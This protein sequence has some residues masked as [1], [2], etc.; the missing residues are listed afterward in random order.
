M[1]GYG[2]DG[3][4]RRGLVGSENPM[5]GKTGAKNPMFGK[6]HTPEALAKMRGR[7]M[8]E[9]AKAKLSESRKG[10]KSVWWGKRHSPETRAKMS[11]S[12]KAAKRD[13]RGARN[14]RWLGGV[15][16]EPYAWTFNEELK[17]EVRRRDGYRCQKCGV[18]QAECRR[19]LDVHHVD[20][21]K[22]NSDPVNLVA[23]CEPCH[24]RVNVNRRH[25]TTVFQAKAIERSIK[26][27][28]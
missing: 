8:S 5:W 12:A 9:E 1:T 28:E 14:P 22:K 10:S 6:K 18:P 20:Y 17:E 24:S 21:D 26:E 15:S 7:K 16:A 2:V 13:F 27:H 19:A 4:R 3:M 11:A 23:L 25:W